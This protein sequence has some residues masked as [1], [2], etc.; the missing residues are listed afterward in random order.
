MLEA[1]HGPLR[2]RDPRYLGPRFANLG[3]CLACPGVIWAEYSAHWT[4]D[5]RKKPARG[6]DPGN[7]RDHRTAKHGDPRTGQRDRGNARGA[8]GPNGRA[9][10]P[11]TGTGTGSAPRVSGLRTR[12]PPGRA[13]LFRVW[14]GRGFRSPQPLVLRTLR[15]KDGPRVDRLRP[16]RLQP[17]AQ[18][19]PGYRAR[20]IP[21][22]RDPAIPGGRQWA[23]Y[24]VARSGRL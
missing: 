5:S 1:L 16:L 19:G 21:R 18:A 3:A 20:S 17:R 10:D 4:H 14:A 9:S 7:S 2:R 12:E 8:R 22:I 24:Q 23:A 11:G 6:P 15:A 13:F